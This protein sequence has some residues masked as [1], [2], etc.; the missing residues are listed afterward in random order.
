MLVEAVLWVNDGENVGVP[1][2]VRRRN[3]RRDNPILVSV[4]ELE[5]LPVSYEIQYEGTS[6]SMSRG[7]GVASFRY[8]P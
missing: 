5:D 4:H 3:W 6:Q 1:P 8:F 7:F 2:R